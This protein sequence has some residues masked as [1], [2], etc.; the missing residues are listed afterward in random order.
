MTKEKL[1]HTKFQ[2]NTEHTFMCVFYCYLKGWVLKIYRDMAISNGFDFKP[3][4]SIKNIETNLLR[5]V[6]TIC[7]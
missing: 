1:A 2:L 4:I 6:I 5:N 3:Q 7:C